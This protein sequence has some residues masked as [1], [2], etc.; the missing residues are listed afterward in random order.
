MVN[1]HE[2]KLSAFLS[3][4]TGK[5]IESR[6]VAEVPADGFVENKIPENRLGQPL[7][8]GGRLPDHSPSSVGS[9]GIN[10]VFRPADQV[11]IS[12]TA[13][14]DFQAHVNPIQSTDY[15]GL[16]KFDVRILDRVWRLENLYYVVNEDGQ[17]VKFKLREAQKWLLQNMSW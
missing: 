2:N 16:E 6:A 9:I 11:S 12:T 3:Q 13:L 10:S 8:N 7:A 14:E 17:L 1:S 15:V 5:N 4:G